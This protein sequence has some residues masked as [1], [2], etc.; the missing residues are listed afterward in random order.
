MSQPENTD[1]PVVN[2]DDMISFIC[3]K[4]GM[5]DEQV[6]SVLNAETDFLISAGII[7]TA[8]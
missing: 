3:G 4:T 6:E 8:E 5:I 1:I 2:M 7:T